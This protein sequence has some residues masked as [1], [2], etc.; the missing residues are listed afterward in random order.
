MRLSRI[1]RLLDLNAF[2]FTFTVAILCP[3]LLSSIR[4]N[5]SQEMDYR[6]IQGMKRKRRR[7]SYKAKYMF[8]TFHMCAAF[9]AK[10]H[11]KIVHEDDNDG[12]FEE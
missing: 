6:H 1:C 9:E 11:F 7:K 12:S 4:Y 3:R 5:M 8:V 10:F 2:E